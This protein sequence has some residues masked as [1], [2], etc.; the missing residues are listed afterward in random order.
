MQLGRLHKAHHHGG[1]LP[2]LFVAT[3]ELRITPHRPW[4]HQ[5]LDM[6]VVDTDVTIVQVSTQ[7]LPAFEAVA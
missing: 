6:V 2:S 3:E 7:R 5:A 4:A 1:P